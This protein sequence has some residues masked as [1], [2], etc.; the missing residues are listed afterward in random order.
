MRPDDE[1]AAPLPRRIEGSFALIHRPD[2]AN[3]AHVWLSLSPD[4]Q[5]WGS[6]KLMLLARKGAWWDAKRVGLSPPLIETERGWLIIHHGVRHTAAGRLHRLGLALFAFDAP[7]F[8]P[9]RGESWIFSAEA[10]YARNGDVGHV[11]FPCGHTL[12]ADGDQ[13]N[14]YD[15]AADTSLALARGSLRQM[16]C[17]L[18]ENSGE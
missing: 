1:D 16:L 14:L 4:L 5:N 8:C 13:I 7:D 12:G 9:K 2:S 11:T 10:P 15:G 17:W 18:D 6:H 3:G